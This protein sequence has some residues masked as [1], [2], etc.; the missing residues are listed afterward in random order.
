MFKKISAKYENGTEK[1]VVVDGQYNIYEPTLIFIDVLYGGYKLNTR[2]SYI[3]RVVRYLNFLCEKNMTYD[4]VTPSF[5]SKYINYLQGY[6]IEGVLP[7]ERKLLGSSVNTN[8]AAIAKFYDTLA[9]RELLEAGSPFEYVDGFNPSI[10]YREFLYHA[11]LNKGKVRRR[12][13]R[14]KN[15]SKGLSRERRKTI[16]EIEAFKKHL[17]SKR[18]ILICDI[19]YET[20]MRI[21][22][23]LNLNISDYSEP[24]NDGFGC[25]NIVEREDNDYPSLTIAES[26]QVKT[27]S[28]KVDVHNGIIKRLDEY[29]TT[30]RPYNPG[31]QGEEFIFVSNKRDARPI[32]RQAI[33][34]V[35]VGTSKKSGVKITPHDLRHTHITE[36]TEAG[37]DNAFI[38]S[39]IGHSNPSS[40]K[41]YQHPGQ[42]AQREAYIRFYKKKGYQEQ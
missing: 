40:L 3:D 28:R 18:D 35:F 29:I 11:K 22:D 30:Y 25:I 10:I 36:L 24:G 33:E 41:R 34:K 37:Y 15:Y 19:L 20:G 12:R 9:Q 26:R 23:L 6:E 4:E 27:G 13:Q 38:M 7:L 1:Y 17:P 14:V 2:T 21:S 8:L 31:V 39:R 16:E 5:I 32:S 42:I